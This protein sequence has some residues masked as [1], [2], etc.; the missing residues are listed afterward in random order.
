MLTILVPLNLTG[1]TSWVAK[2][3]DTFSTWVSFVSI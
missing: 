3:L 2:F 1:S